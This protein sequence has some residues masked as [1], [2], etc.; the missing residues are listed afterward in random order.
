MNEIRS[1]AD[2]LP[3]KKWRWRD[4]D[5]GFHIPQEME[6]RHLFYTLRMIWNHTMPPSAH[7]GHNRHYY[8]FGSFYTKDY[9]KAAILHITHEL[10]KR[11]DMRTD[12]TGELNKMRSYFNK[13]VDSQ[14]VKHYIDTHGST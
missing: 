3:G 10:A 13:C 2:F 7:V 1:I 12:W 6:T 11:T 9:M 5:G 14:G 8:N 4:R